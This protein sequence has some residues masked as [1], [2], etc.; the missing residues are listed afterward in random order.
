MP[1]N[2]TPTH[3]LAYNRLLHAA[4]FLCMAGMVSA[5]FLMEAKALRQRMTPGEADLFI[6]VLAMPFGTLVLLCLVLATDAIIEP[7]SRLA[8]HLQTPS[9]QW[10]HSCYQHLSHFIRN[11]LIGSAN[12][13][14]SLRYFYVYARFYVAVRF[15]EAYRQTEAVLA[16]D[17]IV[18]LGIV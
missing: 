4:C 15:M 12:N 14:R 13:S 10:A 7:C 11:T 9:E 2:L 6:L 1:I 16:E 5:C 3:R 18:P 8:R 17:L